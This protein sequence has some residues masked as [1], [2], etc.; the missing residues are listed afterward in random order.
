MTKGIV[1][2]EFHLTVFAPRDLPELEYEASRR[3]LDDRRFQ[4]DLRRAV[5]DVARQYPSLGKVRVRLS[6]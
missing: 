4:G 2:D 3:T 6:R 1:I 5:R